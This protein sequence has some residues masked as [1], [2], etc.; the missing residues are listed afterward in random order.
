MKSSTTEGQCAEGI[1]SNEI[2]FCAVDFTN[3]VSS[4]G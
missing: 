3:N 2:P 4:S 1:F